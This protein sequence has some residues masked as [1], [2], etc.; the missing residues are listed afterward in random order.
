[1]TSPAWRLVSFV[2][3]LDSWIEL[4]APPDDVRQLVTA[5]IFT[6]MDD[7]FEGARREPNFENLWFAVIPGSIHGPMSVVGCSYWIEVSTRT[8]RCDSIA[9]LSHPA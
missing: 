8:V 1:M 3:R 7:P 5:W 4:E 2:E 9:T 6:R